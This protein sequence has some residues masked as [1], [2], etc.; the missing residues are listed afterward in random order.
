[1]SN[2]QAALIAFAKEGIRASWE[3]SEVDS[4]ELQDLA[5]KHGL[6]ADV[7]YD[8][9]VHGPHEDGAPTMQFAGPLASDR[10]NAPAAS[11]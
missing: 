3:G 1:M 4:N 5:R 6:V 7:P 11:A 10:S 2:D 9:A 8:P